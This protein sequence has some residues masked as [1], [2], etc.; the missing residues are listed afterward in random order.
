MFKYL[1]V[2][3]VGSIRYRPKF[4]WE[5]K[6]LFLV[7]VDHRYGSALFTERPHSSTA[8]TTGCAGHAKFGNLRATSSENANKIQK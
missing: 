6:G 2:R 7:E 5:S 1:P 3:L 4:Y 8:M